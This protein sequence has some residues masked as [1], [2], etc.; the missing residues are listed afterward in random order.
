M[1]SPEIAFPS[2]LSTRCVDEFE[3][4][5]KCLSKPDVISTCNHPMCWRCAK[6]WLPNCQGRCPRANRSGR[7]PR[8]NGYGAHINFLPLLKLQPSVKTPQS[9]NTI[10]PGEQSKSVDSL[11]TKIE[12]DMSSASF[13]AR[14]ASGDLEQKHCPTTEFTAQYLKH[15]E[16]VVKELCRLE[17]QKMISKQIK[18]FVKASATSVA[19][20]KEEQLIPVIDQILS[21]EAIE[22]IMLNINIILNGPPKISYEERCKIAHKIGKHIKNDKTLQILVRVPFLD[23]YHDCRNPYSSTN[24]KIYHVMSQ[25]FYLLDTYRNDI[26]DKLSIKL[27]Q[28]FEGN[29]RCE[30][31]NGIIPRG[32]TMSGPSQG[33]QYE[34]GWSRC[35]P[36]SDEFERYAEQTPCLRIT[37]D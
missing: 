8:E 15:K 18:A 13:T 11:L 3:H 31:T 34:G 26:H 14:P 10:L 5:I 30:I 27:S 25:S 21:P 35:E 20:Q 1:S 29:V 22:I 23:S 28:L 7:C 4:C 17:E 16:V 19:L 36:I 9:K 12:N 24:K 33:R 6:S 32:G 2:I 37:F